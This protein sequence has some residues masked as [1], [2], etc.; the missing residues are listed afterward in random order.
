[1]KLDVILTPAELLALDKRDLSKTACV[2]FDILRATSTFGTA[3]QNGAKEIV[4]VSETPEALA[5]KKT[6]PDTL[7]GGERN[8]VR[9]SS[10]GIDFDFGN[11]PRE[12]T[13]KKV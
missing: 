6:K 4:P 1:M 11:S 9:I 3:L 8:G 12:Y 10:D 5:I 2:V 7:L 13:R